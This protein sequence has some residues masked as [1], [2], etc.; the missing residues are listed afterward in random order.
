MKKFIKVLVAVALVAPTLVGCGSSS[1][2][3]KVGFGMVIEPGDGKQ[4]NTTMAT[5]GLDKDGKVAYIDIDVAQTPNG[6]DEAKTKDELKEQYGMAG[7]SQSMGVI[8]ENG[9]EWFEQIEALEQ[10]CIGKTGEEIAAIETEARD[11]NHP[12]VP[13]AGSDLTAGCTMNIASFKQAIAKA[14]DNA[15]EVEAETIGSGEDISWNGTQVNTTVAQVAL[16]KDGK[17]VWANL[18]VAQTPNGKDETKSKKELKEQY[19]MAAVSQSFGVITENS[20]ELFEQLEFFEEY[21]VG[22]TASDVAGIETEARDENH[23][24]VPKAGSDL[25]AGCTINIASFQAALAE[26]FETA[27]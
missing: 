22:K 8:T 27:R 2:Y 1:K 11:E 19:G 10:Y 24:A 18:D 26:A 13:K 12:A 9:G 14:I 3:A 15:V 25:T 20:G 7:V 4:T 23:P 21:I 6:K 16:D 5:V 17:V